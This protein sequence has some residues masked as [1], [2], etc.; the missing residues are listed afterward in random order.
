MTGLLHKF[1]LNS[2]DCC[3]DVFVTG[4]DIV[5]KDNG[6]RPSTMEQLARLKP[7]FVKPHGTVTA[8]NSSFLVSLSE[9]IR[10]YL[11][12]FYP[13]NLR[14]ICQ[15]CHSKMNSRCVCVFT[16]TDGASAVLI[17]S[18]EKALA[19][20]YKPKAYLRYK[21]KNNAL[22]LKTITRSISL[23]SSVFS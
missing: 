14:N 19:M 22:H 1:D 20:G 8:A 18:E 10:V 3:D 17:M 12:C 2:S 15:F 11:V 5:S 21:N 6:I 7:A 23:T 4:K 9:I 13:F 16:Q